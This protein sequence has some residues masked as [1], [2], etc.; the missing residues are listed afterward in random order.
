MLS[1]IYGRP[2]K[3][4]YT[5]VA[6]VLMVVKA[7]AKGS[8]SAP[9]QA[10]NKTPSGVQPLAPSGIVRGGSG[11][12]GS[13][14]AAVDTSG[15]SIVSQN[16]NHDVSPPLISM[17]PAPDQGKPR[18]EH[19][20]GHLP[21]AQ[22]QGKVKDPV[23]Q[24][25]F[26]PLAIPTPIL[27][28]DGVGQGFTGPNGTFTVVSAPPD[29]NGAVGPN[30]SVQI[31]NTDFAIFNKSGT[32]IYGPVPIN[33][34]WSGFGGGCQTNNDGDP[35]VVYD[36]ISDRWVI[37]Q[38][39]VSTTPY[40]Q[41]VAVSQTADPTGAYNR[42]SF[43][44]GTAFNDYPK[45]GV[46]PDA[47]YVT[48]NM[49]A[50]GTT[51][52]GAKICA[53]DRTRMLAGQAATQQCFDTSTSYGGLL[54]SDL[55]GSRLPP[56]GSPNYILSLGSAANTLAFWKFHVDWTTPG[57]S[58]FIGPTT[59][60]TAAY[61]EACGGG[62]CIPQAG[63]T[64][65]LDSLA[66]RLMYRLAYRNF[67]DHEALVTNHSITA[68]ASV[69]VR[70]YEIRSPGTTPAI[71]QQG[72]YAPDSNYRWM[73]SIAQ[74]QS[75]NMALGFS[76]S[77]AAL[78]P[79]ISY[80]GRLAGDAFGQMTQGVGTI[81]AGGGSQ[82]GSSLTRWGDYS[83]MQVDPV[84]DCTFWYTTE[85][86]PVDGA[87]N[88][89][90]RIASFKFPSC[91]PPPPTST[92]TSTPTNT[93][94]PTNTPTA[95]S[96]PAVIGGLAGY[97][98][99]DEGSGTS[100]LDAS[101][102][103][104]NGS[105]VNAP[106]Y[107]SDVPSTC[108]PPSDLFSLAFV[109]AS[110][111]HVTVPDSPSLHFPANTISVA[112]WIKLTG[113]STA[114][115]YSIVTKGGGVDG[116]NTS[117]ILGI[118]SSASP[119]NFNQLGLYVNGTW[120]NSS[121]TI[122]PNVWQHVAA[123]YDG[124][125]VRLYINGVAAGSSPLAGSILDRSDPTMIGRQGTTCNCNYFQGSIDEA[126]IY[127]RALT[128]GEISALAQCNPAPTP[129]NTPTITLT[130]TITRT[131]TPTNTPTI[132]STPTI[133]PTPSGL[134]VGHVTWQGPSAQPNV[135]QQL[136][137]SLTLCVG[138]TP[139]GYGA[140]TDSSGF[141]TVTTSLPS[142]SYNWWAKG[143]KYLATSGTAALLGGGTT[144]VE[145]GQQRTGD[146]D[147]SHNNVVNATDFSTLKGV[148]GS[149]S[150]V[151]DLNND[152]VTNSVDFNLLRGNFGTSGAAANCP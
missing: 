15:H 32:P 16:V 99:F 35:V 152:G 131:N 132:T 103:A 87:F 33:T 55:D 115:S 58:T 117:Y 63:T 64:Q 19:E 18:F 76:L 59:L 28:F 14:S 45:M 90:T 44:Y 62:T 84:D 52:S 8:S 145:M 88:W 129:T 4:I 38:F 9:T 11:A 150:A 106:T 127:N 17:K 105:L 10:Q 143:A 110:S 101:G 94:T 114:Q 124:A 74:D 50:N 102:N 128:A 37:S 85:Y 54:P 12:R 41:C 81:I 123:T 21:M 53:F 26:S 29:T 61:A 49:F 113:S 122:T 92:P 83:A 69:G 40:L 66:D 151:G 1:H 95:T 3:I 82:I 139:A 118:N 98:K 144:Q 75:G 121:S 13:T 149:A 141:F 116:T 24:N 93:N 30:H 34:L 77:G 72:T 133:T 146:V 6:L 80:T 57:N 140:T 125:T 148:F 51:F 136:P 25:W 43:S 48:Y 111:Q 39:S 5:L 112:A 78:R 135:G 79:T 46:W 71:I 68:G 97:W 138:G 73:G 27:N 22:Q 86:I 91:A 126:R 60:A 23:L 137:I 20:Q 108:P 100:A 89:R 109:R 134:I 107:S 56:A 142:G 104:N 47:Y 36:R 130:P 7:Q 96:T 2:A 120:T 67:G 119:S 65:Q 70:W 31:V 42:Y 147:S